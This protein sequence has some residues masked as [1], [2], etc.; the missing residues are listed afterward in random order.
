VLR[1]GGKYLILIWDRLDRNSVSEAVNQA[2][3]EEFPADPPRFLE[4][5]PFGYWD[6]AQIE[7]DLRS[8]G[9]TQIDL[10]TVAKSSVVRAEE[11]AT[12]LCRGSPLSVEILERD[13]AA[14]DRVVDAARRALQRF[15]GTEAPMSA[16]VVTA[17]R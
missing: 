7:A 17:T 15:D 14:M 11:A 4:R 12:S 1:D 13:P 9:F 3:A 6:P 5:A 2:V 8:A 10:E 16:H